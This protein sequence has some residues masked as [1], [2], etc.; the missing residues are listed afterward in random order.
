MLNRVKK[1][2]DP[3]GILAV[4]LVRIIIGVQ[5]EEGHDR[6]GEAGR[7]LAVR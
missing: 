2:R 6:A 4:V 3:H 7:D 1:A 5:K